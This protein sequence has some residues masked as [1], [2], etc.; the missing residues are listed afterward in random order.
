MLGRVAALSAPKAWKK[1]I[2]HFFFAKRYIKPSLNEFDIKRQDDKIVPVEPAGKP[3]KQA[4]SGTEWKSSLSHQNGRKGP[5]VVQPRKPAMNEI[6]LVP[7]ESI[8]VSSSFWIEK[9]EYKFSQPMLS[10]KRTGTF[11]M[12]K[13]LV[14]YYKI[15]SFA[16]GLSLNFKY[17]RN[18]SYDLSL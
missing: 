9:F 18:K 1:N 4:V 15:S 12:R 13:A 2:C 3:T 8:D 5:P 10:D 17:V 14:G 6:D 7:G 11:M 16:H